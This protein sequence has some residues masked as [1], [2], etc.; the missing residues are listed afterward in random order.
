MV[1]KDTETLFTQSSKE[2]ILERLSE[3]GVNT[4]YLGELSAPALFSIVKDL[5]KVISYSRE[6][7]TGNSTPILS[8]ID[9]KIL[10]ALLS[11]S[12]PTSSLTLSKELDIP[13]S[14]VQRRRMRLQNNFLNTSYSLK[15]TKLG[16][17]IANLFLSIDDKMASPIEDYLLSLPFL[18]S[19]DHI[20]GDIAAD[21][22]VTIVFRTNSELLNTIENIKSLNG[23]KNI[24]WCE[25]IR[26]T[27][28]NQESLFAYFIE[29]EKS[30][31][32]KIHGH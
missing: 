32:G 9:K 15:T 22:I 20:I 16:L 27:C 14:T 13:L 23:V 4:E 5:E 31:D 10:K 17:R 28:R 18:Q 1:L 2:K 30:G 26:D 12:G 7:S 24:H 11:S 21:L 3:L 25:K 29:N 6:S 8:S 19:I